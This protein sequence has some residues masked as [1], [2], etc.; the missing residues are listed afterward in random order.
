MT[1]APGSHEC[2]AHETGAADRSDEDVAGR[3][4]P[5]KI[6]R[7]GMAH[8]HGGVPV[9]QKHR[10]RL[11]DDIA[12]ANDH[13][14]FSG[15]IDAAAVQQLDDPRRRACNQIGAILHQSPDILRGDA[16]NILRRIDHVEHLLHGRT[17][18]E[19]GNGA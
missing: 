3:G 18:S 8:R 17:P 7:P 4:N 1:V 14:M 10:Y 9:Q 19:S 16:V 2:G 5:C 15:D 11:A 13:G 12:A 6:L